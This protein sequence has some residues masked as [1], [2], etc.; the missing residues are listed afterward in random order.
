MIKTTIR[1]LKN[2]RI[3]GHHYNYFRD[4]DPKLGRCMQADPIAPNG[5]LN[6][7]GYVGQSPLMY[8]GPLWLLR[9]D[10]KKL[11]CQYLSQ[12][13]WDIACAYTGAY[14][15]VSKAHVFLH[16]VPKYLH[17]PLK[18]AKD[19]MYSKIPTAS[20]PSKN[21]KDADYEYIDNQKNLPGDWRDFCQTC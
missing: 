19:N 1:H 16:S 15:N 13:Q 14:D 17:K 11:L 12:C 9:E 18:W 8:T 2:H 6:R 10:T 4:Y 21:P 3:T 20:K 5:G 7:Y